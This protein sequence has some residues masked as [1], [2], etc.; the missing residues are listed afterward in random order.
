MEKIKK[1]ECFFQNLVKPTSQGSISREK[2]INSFLN[3]SFMST[4]AKV[5]TI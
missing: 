5:M 3:F 4:T 1:L 2:D